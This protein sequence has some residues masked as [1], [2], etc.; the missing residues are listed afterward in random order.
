MKVGELPQTDIPVPTGVNYTA[1]AEGRVWN[2]RT[3]IWDPFTGDFEKE[4][5]YFPV[6]KISTLRAQAKVR[7]VAEGTE[8]IHKAE[9]TVKSPTAGDQ[10]SVDPVITLPVGVN[11]R[12]RQG[13]RWIEGSP[14]E[15][16]ILDNHYFE[17]DGSYGAD[18]RLIANEGYAFAENAAPVTAPAA[19][20]STPVRVPVSGDDHTIYVDAVVQGQK[21][22]IN[23]AD[24]SACIPSSAT[25]WRI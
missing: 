7:Y 24:L 4:K 15:Y 14:E 12:L 25:M 9:V 8:V 11:Y 6:I 1:K 18:F 20:V 17:A 16:V 13:G 2:N 22:T 23:R 21:A 19:P 5:D 10:S 3:E